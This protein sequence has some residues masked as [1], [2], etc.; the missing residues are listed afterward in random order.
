M[1]I[2]S[3]SHIQLVTDFGL[4][5]F[6]QAL[7]LRIVEWIIA[8]AMRGGDDMGDAVGDRRFGHGQRLFDALRAVIETWQ[9]VAMHIHHGIR[10]L[11]AALA[12]QRCCILGRPTSVRTFTHWLL[13]DGCDSKL[14]AGTRGC[15]L[16]ILRCFA[17]QSQRSC[18]AVTPSWRVFLFAPR[19]CY[20]YSAIESRTSS[21]VKR[22]SCQLT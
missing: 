4:Q 11:L 3:G 19:T 22:D 17:R 8:A 15:V 10:E 9:N 16:T 7:N 1:K 13:N 21:G 2:A 5:A 14:P 6:A 18:P 20:I 12:P